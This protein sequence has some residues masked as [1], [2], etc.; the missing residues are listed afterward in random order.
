VA[1]TAAGTVGLDAAQDVLSLVD[2]GVSRT[3]QAA[4]LGRQQ[5]RVVMPSKL[6]EAL[7]VKTRNLA[8]LGDADVDLV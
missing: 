3:R 7:T 8:A 5:L 4:G 2:H 1:L 6:P